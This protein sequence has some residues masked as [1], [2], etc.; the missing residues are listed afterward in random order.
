LTASA[1]IVDEDQRID[2]QGENMARRRYQQGR[3]FLRGKNPPKWIGRWREDILQ[4]NGK[5]KRV[6]RSV[7]LGTKAELLTERFAR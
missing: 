6:E 1:I 7:V 3:L 4:Q 5:V 2:G